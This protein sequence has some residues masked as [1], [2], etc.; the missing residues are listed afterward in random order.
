MF[1]PYD[2]QQAGN[3]HMVN[4]SFV[5]QS[6]P[7]ICCQLQKWGGFAEMTVTQ[8]VEVPQKVSNN[9]EDKKWKFQEEHMNLQNITTYRKEAQVRTGDEKG[10]EKWS[11][12]GS[13]HL[14]LGLN[15]CAYRKE[16]GY[17]KH[18]CPQLLKKKKIKCQ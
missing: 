16:I 7:D 3:A 9:R 10:E 14:S 17:L 6:A 12:Q 4:M 18:E 15:Q 11:Q 1:T 2:P 5:T 8:L 13:R